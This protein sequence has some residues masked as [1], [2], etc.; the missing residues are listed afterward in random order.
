MIAFSGTKINLGLSVKRKR[1]DGFHELETVFYPLRYSDVLEVVPSD[2]FGFQTSGIPISGNQHE[3][4]VVKAYDRIRSQY[5]TGCVKIHLHKI[6]PPGTGLGGGSADAAAML[7]L[8][9][10]LFDLNLE[11][12]ELEAIAAELGSDCPFFINHQPSLATGRGEVLQPMQVS[13]KGYFIIVVLPRL[14]ISTE[15]AYRQVKPKEPL[16]HPSSIIEKSPELWK[17]KLINDFE[18]LPII[19][20]EIHQIKSQ[21]YEQGAL[22][23]SLSG[24]GSAVYGIFSQERNMDDIKMEY[25]VYKQVLD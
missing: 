6:V 24:S 3:N 2:T 16:H 23:A 22:Y 14:S 17:G 1:R 7:L 25:R 10:K 20:E 11:A 13:L 18:Q 9:N 4:L 21:L 5:N 12:R 19:P 8:M 15:E